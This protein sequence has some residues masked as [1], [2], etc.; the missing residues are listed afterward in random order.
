MKAL[1]NIEM[2]RM[3][4]LSRAKNT[5]KEERVAIANKGGEAMK[6]KTKNDPDYY[7]RI[8]ALAAIARAKKK[9][10]KQ[11]KEKRVEVNPWEEITTPFSSDDN[12]PKKTPGIFSFLRGNKP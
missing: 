7:K 11:A 3:G 4:G 1:T 8:S 6:E 12:K 5:T 2:G 10:I 9:A